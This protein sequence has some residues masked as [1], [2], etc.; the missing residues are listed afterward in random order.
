MYGDVPPEE[1]SM[2]NA[3]LSFPQVV[4]DVV[5]LCVNLFCAK[6]VKFCE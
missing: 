4:P 3:P 1:I 5:I 6:T 2:Y